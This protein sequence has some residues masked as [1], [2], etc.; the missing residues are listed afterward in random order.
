MEDI[1]RWRGPGLLDRLY[2]E[3]QC[4]GGINDDSFG[5]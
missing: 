1:F 3:N 4:T 5:L 2:I